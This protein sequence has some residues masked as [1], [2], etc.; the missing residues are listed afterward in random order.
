MSMSEAFWVGVEV[1][2]GL[3]DMNGLGSLDLRK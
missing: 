2:N 3:Y 1:L